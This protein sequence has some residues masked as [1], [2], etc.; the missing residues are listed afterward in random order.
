MHSQGNKY[1]IFNIWGHVIDQW[2]GRELISGVLVLTYRRYL[3]VWCLYLL[4]LLPLEALLFTQNTILPQFSLCV[5]WHY[6]GNDEFCCVY[7]VLFWLGHCFWG[8]G[9]GNWANLFYVAQ[10]LN[11][12]LLETWGLEI[13]SPFCLWQSLI[14][15]AFFAGNIQNRWFYVMTWK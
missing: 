6:L 5:C 3:Q 14:K 7:L 9:E 8:N 1:R 2:W 12:R 4:A 13:Y 15:N 10:I 11:F